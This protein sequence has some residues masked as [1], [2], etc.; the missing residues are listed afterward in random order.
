MKIINNSR[1]IPKQKNYLSNAKYCDYLYSYLQA[2]SSWDGIVGHPRYVYKKVVNFSRIAKDLNKSRQTISKK[3]N[4]MLQ[5]DEEN[6]VMPLIK[7]SQDG[8]KYE[9]IF[10]AGNLAM[11]VP[12]G[13]LKVLVSTL[14]E[15]AISI[16]VYLLNRYIANGDRKF[17][18][19]Y[20]ELKNVIGISSASNGN[21]YIIS[22][23]LFVLSKIDLLKTEQRTIVN[24]QGRT[25]CQNWVIW[26]TNDI[27]D[28]PDQIQG[29]DDNKWAL[30][31]KMTG[32]KR[33]QQ[34]C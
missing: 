15:N 33:I 34:A 25:V 28:L 12:D 19:S 20:S 23:I 7:L 16:Y 2:I 29:Q 1:Q 8:T 9:L 13:T 17:Q 27:D 24:Q 26:M 32:K 31:T 18:F 10:L 22:S 30:Y 6:G 21:N 11:L 3:F 14:K 5:G 4:A